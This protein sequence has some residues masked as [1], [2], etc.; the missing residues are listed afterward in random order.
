MV[1]TMAAAW[2]KGFMEKKPRGHNDK[3]KKLK[4]GIGSS[5]VSMRVA[6]VVYREALYIRTNAITPN[7]WHCHTF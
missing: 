2:F 6:E 1:I 3:K 4:T 5:H 7:L